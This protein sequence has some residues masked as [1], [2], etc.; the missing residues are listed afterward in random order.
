M[1]ILVTGGCGFI[2]SNFINYMIKKYNK[3]KIIN[4]DNL[5]YCA[6][7]QNIEKSVSESDNY[8]FIKGNINDFNLIKYILNEE[9]I[10]HIIHFAAHSSKV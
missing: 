3:Y 7:L 10:T 1:N 4:I 8:K 5:Y 6:S 9:K 2:G